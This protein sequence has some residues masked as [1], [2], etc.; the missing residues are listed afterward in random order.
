MLEIAHAEYMD[1]HHIKLT[2]NDGKSGIADVNEMIQSQPQKLFSALADERVLKQFTLAH[3]TLCW[4]NGL[5]VAPEYLYYLTFK[6]DP[7]LVS[8]FKQWAYV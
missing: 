2:F 8:L 1:N 3:G 5:D 6:H 7:N 4:P